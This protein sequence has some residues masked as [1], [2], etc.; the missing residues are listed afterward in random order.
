M[1]NPISCLWI[2]ILFLSILTSE[3]LFAQ[4]ISITANIKAFGIEKVESS[5]STTTEYEGETS[6]SGNL[7]LFDKNHFALRLGVGLNNLK[8]TFSDSLSTNYDAVR[9]SMT[10]YLGLEKHF[11]GGLLTPYL[12]IYMPLTFNSK[13]EIKDITNTVIG[14]FDG[15]GIKAGLS[16]LGGLNLQLFKVLRLGVEANVGFDSFKEEVFEPL[17]DDPSSIKFK[18]LDFALEATIGVAF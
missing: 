9:E 18:N 3:A 5:G 2:G 7:R 15:E 10:A 11:T 4:R 8:Y 16:L 6:F 1:K 17:I 14:Q 13:D 12:G